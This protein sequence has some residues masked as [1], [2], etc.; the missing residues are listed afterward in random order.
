MT[1]IHADARPAAADLVSSKPDESFLWRRRWFTVHTT[2]SQTR[3]WTESEKIR[4]LMMTTARR[5]ATRPTTRAGRIVPL[6]SIGPRCPELIGSRFGIVGAGILFRKGVAVRS[7]K[8]DDRRTADHAADHQ[9]DRLR[10]RP[11]GLPRERPGVR[12]NTDLW[13]EYALCFPLPAS[14]FRPDGP[15]R[16]RCHD[17]KVY[18]RSRCAARCC[19]RR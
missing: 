1:H 3:R 13:R 6:V 2:T 16:H 9:L 10:V 19:S 14:R 17:R 11:A 7:T 5:R 8:S 18:R 12:Y 4:E 15:Q